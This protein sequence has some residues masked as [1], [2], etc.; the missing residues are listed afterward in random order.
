MSISRS[1]RIRI[2]RIIARLNIGGPAIQAIALTHHFSGP[3]F[4]SLL[5]CG[6]TSPWEGDMMYRAREIGVKPFFLSNLK[7]DLSFRAD[8]Y[9]LWSLLKIIVRFKPHIIHT[10]TAKAGALG[11]IAA[12]LINLARLFNPSIKTVHTFH[13]HVFHS[14]FGSLKTYLF[15]I[16]E[17]VLGFFTDRIV[18]ISHR[19]KNDIC[20]RFKVA[21]SDKVQV[22][23]LGFE[24]NDFFEPSIAGKKALDSAWIA[25][26]YKRYRIVIVGRLTA[27]KNHGMLL[28]AI[29]KLKQRGQEDQFHFYVVG[30]GELKESLLDKVS[31]LALEKSV[32]FMGW[33]Q[34]MPA[35][36]ALM[37]AVVLTSLNEGTPVALIEAMASGKPV[38]AT[39]VGGVPDILGQV[40][41]GLR[42]GFRIWEN[43]IG[44]SSGDSSALC[45]ALL[46]LKNDPKT[47]AQLSM[48]ARNYVYQQHSLERLFKDIEA[49]YLQLVSSP[50]IENEALSKG[51]SPG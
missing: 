36:Y 37:D 17:Q 20:Y 46:F 33:Q 4:Q 21:K 8:L 50:R 30:D 29:Q 27:V 41:S 43:G 38:V 9:T 11:R 28:D 47:V 42:H 13:G 39:E 1:D 31:K 10:H 49:L 12:L 26:N 18:V 16:V 14:Y 35:V 44:V 25:T 34:N 19:Q 51:G 15:R 7:R 2:L 48:N 6:Q 5:T 40:Q 3:R 23:P 24:L 45:E 22:I 32:S